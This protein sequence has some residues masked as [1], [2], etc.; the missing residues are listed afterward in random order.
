MLPFPENEEELYFGLK[1]IA[2]DGR[3]A[4][5]PA[6][7]PERRALLESDLNRILHGLNEERKVK[8]GVFFA[9]AAV[10]AGRKRQRLRFSGGAFARILRSVRNS[11]RQLACPSGHKCCAG[12]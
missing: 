11:R 8:I 3:S 10:F 1:V 6:L 5:I 12:A 9:A 4:L 7:K 2:A